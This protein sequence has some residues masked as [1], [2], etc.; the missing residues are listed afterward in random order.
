MRILSICGRFLKKMTKKQ[1]LK[2]FLQK[3]PSFRAYPEDMVQ[4]LISLYPQYVN[5]IWKERQRGKI[6]KEN[7]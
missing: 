6:S 5:W 7:I 1:Q 3:Y 2:I 4:K